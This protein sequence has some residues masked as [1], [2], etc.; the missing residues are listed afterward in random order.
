M[1]AYRDDLAAAR[2]R[3]RA[4]ESEVRSL[5]RQNEASLQT[6]GSDLVQPGTSHVPTT[7]ALGGVLVLGFVALRVTTVAPLALGALLL[8]LLILSLRGRALVVRPNEIAVVR[9]KRESIPTWV[10]SGRVAR[11]R[12]G[13]TAESLSLRAQPL[14]FTLQGLTTA[15]T[16][17]QAEVFAVLAVRRDDEGIERAVRTFGAGPIEPVSQAALE[18]AIRTLAKGVPSKDLLTRRG[19]TCDRLRRACRESLHELGVDLLMVGLSNAR[20]VEGEP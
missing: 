8:L 6:A 19:G 11:L 2:E 13:A 10:S 3:I 12:R 15:D 20:V 9:G 18:E 1:S 5:Q 16:T 17:I 4:L 14:S 7:L